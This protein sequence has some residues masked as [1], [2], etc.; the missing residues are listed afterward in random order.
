MAGNQGNIF[1]LGILI[2]DEKKEYQFD[3]RF[4]AVIVFIVC[5]LVIGFWQAKKIIDRSQG[6]EVQNLLNIW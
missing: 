3:W 4:Y 6:R 2:M 5:L 1:F